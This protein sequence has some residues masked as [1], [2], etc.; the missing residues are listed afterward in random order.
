[1]PDIEQE[2]ELPGEEDEEII[3]T[4]KDFAAG[5]IDEVFFCLDEFAETHNID[6]T[7]M[8]VVLETDKVADRASHWEAGAKQ[9]FDTGLYNATLTL[10]VKAADYGKR[11]KVGKTLIFDGGA[12]QYRVLNWREDAGV[13]LMNVERVRM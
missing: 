8:P 1:M 12:A 11:P 13:Y 10:Y 2:Y 4:F 6:G 3:K 7:D 5:D 9:N